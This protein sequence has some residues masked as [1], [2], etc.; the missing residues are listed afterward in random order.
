MKHGN[1]S[2]SIPTRAIEVVEAFFATGA[3]K[4]AYYYLGE[5]KVGC[6]QWDEDGELIFECGMRG[7]VKHGREYCFDVGQP[8]EMTPYRHG[9]IHGTGKQWAADGRLLVTYKLINGVG[10]DLWCGNDN[11][12]LSEEHYWPGD[13]E[14]GYRRNWNDDEKTIWEEYCFSDNGHHGIWRQWNGKGRLRRGFPQFFVNNL[15]VT[16]R[17]YLKASKKDTT[18]LPYR[19]EE[20]QPNRKLPAE[21]LAQR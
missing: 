12:T 6:R 9:L 20:D 1:Y 2:A 18:L 16:K 14:R 8:Y 11:D 7:G 15:R 4:L 13:G 19:L 21:Y 17:Q 3:R 5:E 10:L